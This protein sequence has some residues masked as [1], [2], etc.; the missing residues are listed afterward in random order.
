MEVHGVEVEGVEVDG[1]TRCAHYDGPRDVVA[2]RFPCCGRYYPCF[3]CHDAVADHE[4]NRWPIEDRDERA[5]LCG[6]CGVQLAIRE[7]L[8]C[9][10]ACPE[11][12]A[13]FNPGCAS[14]FRHYFERD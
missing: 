6:V 12:D 14:H 8:D 10:H 11:C 5:V 2:I 7:Y 13:A 1:R 4:R 9:D 3:A